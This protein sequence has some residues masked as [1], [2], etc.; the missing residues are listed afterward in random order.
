MLSLVDFVLVFIPLERLKLGFPVQRHK[1]DCIYVCMF[2]VNL[3]RRRR[4]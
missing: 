3:L 4:G 1:S 2:F